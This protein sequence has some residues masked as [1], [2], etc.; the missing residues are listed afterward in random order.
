[1]KYWIG[2]VS[3]SHVENGKK[4][5]I[6]QVCHGKGGA[7]KRMRKGDYLLYYSPTVTY[8]KKDPYQKFTALGQ[9]VDED[10]YQFDMGGGFTPFRRRIHYFVTQDAPIRPLLPRLS[11]I[12][13]KEKW[14]AVFRYGLLS[15]PREDFEIIAAAMDWIS[16]IK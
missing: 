15:I 12:K 10:I 9:L 3:K 4:E 1:M 14:G 16:P 11:F 7:L 5:S 6:C 13:N 8:G 2:V